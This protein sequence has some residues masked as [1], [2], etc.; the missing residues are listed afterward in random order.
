MSK[1]AKYV[2]DALSD[3][4]AACRFYDQFYG[5]DEDDDLIELNDYFVC[6]EGFKC[7]CNC[8]NCEYDGECDVCE[9]DGSDYCTECIHHYGG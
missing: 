7:A 2:E 1:D 9:N 5:D 3:Y 4:E 6:A 8:E